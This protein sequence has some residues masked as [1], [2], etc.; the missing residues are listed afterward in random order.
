MCAFTGPDSCFTFGMT[1][2]VLPVN[3]RQSLFASI[4]YPVVDKDGDL[5]SR[6]FTEK[7]S[8]F[9]PKKIAV[10]AEW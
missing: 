6:D 2:P 10:D 7:D 1:S 5:L 8:K 9:M 4:L 3:S